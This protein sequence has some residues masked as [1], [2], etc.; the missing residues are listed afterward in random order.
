MITSIPEQELP[1]IIAAM[2]EARDRVLELKLPN[3]PFEDRLVISL[4]ADSVSA[5]LSYPHTLNGR[6]F[7]QI[8]FDPR[9]S[10]PKLVSDLT[11]LIED[12][13]DPERYERDLD[14]YKTINYI[15]GVDR[16]LGFNIY[17]LFQSTTLR[18]KV[19]RLQ[20]IAGNLAATASSEELATALFPADGGASDGL[21]FATFLNAAEKAG[22]DV[23]TIL[24]LGY[25]QHRTGFDRVM[26]AISPDGKLAG[27]DDADQ[28]AILL[29]GADFWSALD[30]VAPQYKTARAMRRLK[31]IHKLHKLP[32]V[33]YAIWIQGTTYQRRLIDAMEGGS[34]WRR[35]YGSLF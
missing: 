11:Q 33:G 24:R 20:V 7:V 12:L 13:L 10:N 26:Q 4:N 34:F 19:E 27:H 31:L 2:L 22:H 1:P 21:V 9:A 15:M 6:R 35:N 29:N 8:P 18:L 23:T 3:S 16:R 28:V 30:E 5:G 17:S 14:P 25:L 32:F